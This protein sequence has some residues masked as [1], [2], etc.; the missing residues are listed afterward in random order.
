MFKAF[1]L[2][3]GAILG[4]VLIVTAISLVLAW[5]LSILWNLCLVPAVAGLHEVGVF[6]M[7][8]IS[9]LLGCLFKTFVSNKSSK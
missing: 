7:W 3:L 5:P 9:V 2:A 6:Q 4:F 1:T 8:G